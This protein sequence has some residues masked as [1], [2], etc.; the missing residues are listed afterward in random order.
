MLA[1][2]LGLVAAVL[3]VLIIVLFSVNEDWQSEYCEELFHG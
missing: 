3:I 1:I 2:L